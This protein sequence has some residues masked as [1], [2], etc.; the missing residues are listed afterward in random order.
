M[1]TIDAKSR[2][3]GSGSK[4]AFWTLLFLVHLLGFGGFIAYKASNILGRKETREMLELDVETGYFPVIFISVG[5]ALMFALTWIVLVR[6][7]AQTILW[8]AIT[9]SLLIMVA[10]C[11]ICVAA[12]N[13]VGAFVCGV[14]LFLKLLYVYWVRERIN[15]TGELIRASAGIMQEYPGITFSSFAGLFMLLKVLTVYGGAL[16]ILKY[17]LGTQ[18]AAIK[19]EKDTEARAILVVLAFSFYWTSA[20]VGNAVHTSICGIVGRWYFTPGKPAFGSAWAQTMTRSFGSVAYGSFILAAVRTLK[21]LSKMAK[22]SAN[23]N[24]NIVLTLICCCASCIL[25][26]VEDVLEFIST[27]AYVYVAIYGSSFCEGAQQTMD[28]LQHSGVDAI[29]AYDYSGLVTFFGAL[30]GGGVTLATSWAVVHF[31]G[32]YLLPG[33]KG[34]HD[35]QFIGLYLLFAFVIGACAVV[36][37][38]S[39]VESCVTSLLVCFA[40]DPGILDQKHPD[41]TNQMKQYIAVHEEERKALLQDEQQAPGQERI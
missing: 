6:S 9:M 40:E 27:Y 10:L 8:A 11:C 20:F 28:L 25:S 12:K 34:A 4:D 15:F 3:Q 39:A 36:L 37:V 18:G 23:D 38:C 7:F 26:C 22:E 21:L 19:V 24:D 2:F 41:L 1:K 32:E 14:L 17:D 16:A 35:Q 13:M 29:V 5:T 30:V 31:H 33:G